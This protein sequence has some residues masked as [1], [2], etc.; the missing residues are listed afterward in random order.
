MEDDSMERDDKAAVVRWGS[1][2]L[3]CGRVLRGKIW[4]SGETAHTSVRYLFWGT[5]C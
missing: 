5:V 1:A 3:R 2:I 4:Q